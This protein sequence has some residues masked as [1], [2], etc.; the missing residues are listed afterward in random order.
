[1]LS[2]VQL[3][4]NAV[5][6]NS[7]S[8]GNQGD[9]LLALVLRKRRQNTDRPTKRK[10]VNERVTLSGLMKKN[11]KSYSYSNGFLVGSR[12]VAEAR[13]SNEAQLPTELFFS[14][15]SGK[16]LTRPSVNCGGNVLMMGAVVTRSRAC[17]IG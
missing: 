6:R 4:F 5:V 14:I 8:K 1:M 12:V 15:H 9:A 17:G 13:G 10:L 7:T 3:R 11:S 16:H 2:T